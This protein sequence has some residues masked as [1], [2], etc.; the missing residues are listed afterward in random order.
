MLPPH[1]ETLRA[2]YAC[3]SSGCTATDEFATGDLTEVIIGLRS[4]C[5]VITELAGGWR[6]IWMQDT[7]GGRCFGSGGAM[8]AAGAEPDHRE[9]RRPRVGNI[10]RVG[11]VPGRSVL[12]HSAVRS[13]RAAARV[14]L[15]S[16]CVCFA[17]HALFCCGGHGLSNTCP[18]K[19]HADD[20]CRVCL[21]PTERPF[22]LGTT[23]PSP[24]PS[25]SSPPWKSCAT[26]SPALLSLPPCVRPRRSTLQ[27]ARSLQLTA[28][29]AARTAQGSSRQCAQRHTTHGVRFAQQL[30]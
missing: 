28:V 15:T 10:P 14:E 7:S 29:V 9:H 16:V 17:D 1:K 26:P 13:R 3:S 30:A 18:R 4:R 11:G 2:R 8:G 23:E 22:T 12:L 6:G 24:P 27:L 21:R 20:V 19:A 5:A 25:A